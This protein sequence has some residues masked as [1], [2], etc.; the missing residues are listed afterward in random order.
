VAGIG[1]PTFTAPASSW[2]LV[3]WVDRTYSSTPAAGGLATI[4]LDQLPPTDMWLLDHM[5]VQT[6]SSTPTVM[7]LYA[8]SVDPRY[9]R[10]GSDHGNF[11]VGD[12][13]S[14]L[15]CRPSV[16]LVAQWTGCSAGAIATLTLQA[17]VMRRPG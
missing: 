16:S 13:Y 14:G 15:V 11:S 3:D 8:D 5:V 6:T 12:W 2:Q 4:T 1:L 9:I 7:R 17:R 10:D